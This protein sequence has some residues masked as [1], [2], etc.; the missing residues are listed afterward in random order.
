MLSFSTVSSSR[1]TR[2][3]VPPAGPCIT[4]V[5]KVWVTVLVVVL[6]F[7]K[8]EVTLVLMVAGTLS[9]AAQPLPQR[10]AKTRVNLTAVQRIASSRH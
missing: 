3:R 7:V 9:R 2:F 10:G 1:R 4:V 5:V 8:V 6:D